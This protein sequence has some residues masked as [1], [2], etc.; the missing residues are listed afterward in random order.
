MELFKAML[1]SFYQSIAKKAHCT[2][3]AA[4]ILPCNP[5]SGIPE[6]HQIH[7]V[8]INEPNVFLALLN[9]IGSSAP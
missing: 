4:T 8:G 5:M 2:D 7:I 9:F 6:C 3:L 1:H